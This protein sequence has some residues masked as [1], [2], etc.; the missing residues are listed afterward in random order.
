VKQ[1][2]NLTQEVREARIRK[3]YKG[4]GELAEVLL[5]VSRELAKESKP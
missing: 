1:A 5:K 3:A 4:M 2:P